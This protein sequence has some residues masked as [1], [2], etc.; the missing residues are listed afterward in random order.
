ML[1]FND[2]SEIELDKE[3]W[4]TVQKWLDRGDGCAIYENAEL[5]HSDLG[6]RQ[7]VSFGSTFA[8]IEAIEPPQRLPDIGNKINW[9]YQLIGTL[10]GLDKLKKP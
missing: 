7:F 6:H 8:Q 4:A 10:K 9:R 1:I 5:G 2:I 3:H